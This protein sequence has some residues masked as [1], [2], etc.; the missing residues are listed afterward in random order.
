MTKSHTEVKADE[1]LSLFNSHGTAGRW[2]SAEKNNLAA[3][4][5]SNTL[6]ETLHFLSANWFFP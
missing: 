6:P 5:P 1:Q 4:T 2:G 3:V